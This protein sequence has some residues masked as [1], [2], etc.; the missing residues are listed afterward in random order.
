MIQQFYL[1]FTL[2]KI[3]ER[4]GYE[5]KQIISMMGSPLEPQVSFS[6]VLSDYTIDLVI[7]DK[8][9]VEELLRD[10]YNRLEFE[11]ENEQLIKQM[12]LANNAEL[13]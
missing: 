10:Q 4:K 6:V 2:A 9:E 11:S 3:F 7:L 12:K 13:N 8:I 5:I 1:S